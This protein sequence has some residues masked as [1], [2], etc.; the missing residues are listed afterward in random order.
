M[1]DHNT[2]HVLDAIDSA[3]GDAL[4]PDAMRWTPNAEDQPRET[5]TWERIV[6][7][8]ADLIASEDLVEAPTQLARQAGWTIPVALTRAAHADTIAWDHGPLQ[9]ETGR[10]WDVLTLGALAARSGGSGPVPFTLLRVP[11]RAG[12][13]EPTETCLV[14]HIGPGDAGEPVITITAA[15][16]DW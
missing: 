15:E 7:P 3:L 14:L 13:H 2:D 5:D 4:S 6:I 12:A 11:N 8:R 16:E 10:W 1:T 9:D